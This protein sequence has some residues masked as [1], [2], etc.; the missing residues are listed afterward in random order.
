QYQTKTYFVHLVIQLFVRVILM[1]SLKWIILYIKKPDHFK[2]KKLVKL[3][4]IT[5]QTMTLHYRLV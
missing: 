2:K 5:L 3:S 1:L 4:Q